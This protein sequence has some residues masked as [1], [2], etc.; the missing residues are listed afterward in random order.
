MIVAHPDDETLWGGVTLATENGW[1]V[2]CLTN[3]ANRSR[4]T[5]FHKALSILGAHG[6]ILDIPDRRSDPAT[7]ADIKQIDA[8]VAHLLGNNKIQQVMT[9][10]PDGEYGHS[11]HMLIS[12]VVSSQVKKFNDDTGRSISLKYFNFDPEI[13]FSQTRQEVWKTKSR[14]LNAYFPDQGTP[15]SDLRHIELAKHENPQLATEYVRPT[16]LIATIYA[17]STIEIT[18]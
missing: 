2:L 9:H 6:T 5:A 1:G 10:G 4:K 15:D 14:A 17:G 7:P 8:V 18:P 11:F 13:D 3:R 16:D 12:E